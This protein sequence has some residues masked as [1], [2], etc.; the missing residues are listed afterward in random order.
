MV[1]QAPQLLVVWSE[2]SQPFEGSASQLAQPAL[3]RIPQPPA[4]HVEVALGAP[5]QT[6]P[7]APQLFVAVRRLASQP[8]MGLPSQLPKPRRHAR[9]HPL[10]THET[11]AF[12]PAMQTVP[13]AP[14]LAALVCVLVSQPLVATP[15]QSAKPAVQVE[16]QRAAVQVR[17]ALS[18]PGHEVPQAPQLSG[19]DCG[20][21]QV[22]PQRT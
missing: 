17:V 2:T 14:Q 7:Q 8:L 11:V 6:V 16:P 13:H 1:P 9:A 5:G 4:A 19:S 20:S 15:S 18:E 3:H 22:E 21:T 12:E 10:L